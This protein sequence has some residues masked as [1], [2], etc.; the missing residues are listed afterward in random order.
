MNQMHPKLYG[1]IK[2][3]DAFVV[4]VTYIV[5]NFQQVNHCQDIDNFSR[6]QILKS[7]IPLI[8]IKNKKKKRKN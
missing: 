7:S 3:R 4:V 5:D 8:Q 1:N 2:I 6:G